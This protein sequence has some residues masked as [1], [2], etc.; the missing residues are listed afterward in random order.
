MLVDDLMEELFGLRYRMTLGFGGS[1]AVPATPITAR[2]VGRSST[3]K[4]RSSSGGR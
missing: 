3:T 1:C 2:S 4:K